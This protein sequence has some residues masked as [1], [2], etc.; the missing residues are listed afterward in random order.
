M[1]Q[2]LAR[3]AALAVKRGRG[4]PL[5]SAA[6]EGFLPRGRAPHRAHRTPCGGPRCGYG[7]AKVA[8]RAVYQ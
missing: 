1:P 6:E 2:A 5:G 8:R 3:M 7:A 4:E